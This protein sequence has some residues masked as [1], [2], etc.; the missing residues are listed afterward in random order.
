MTL[1]VLMACAGPAHR[2]LPDVPQADA[3]LPGGGAQFCAPA[4]AVDM[5]A[6]LADSGHPSLGP[7]DSAALRARVGELGEVMGVDPE[8]GTSLRRVS[9]GLATWL[10][11]RDVDAS[12][13]VIGWR[14]RD[15]A[16]SRGRQVTL[17]SV[18]SGLLPDAGALLNIGWYVEDEGTL[19]RVGGH[20]VALAGLQGRTAWVVDPSTRAGTT[21]VTHRVALTAPSATMLMGDYV[22]LPVWSADVLSIEGLVEPAG[23][24]QALVDGVVVVELTRGRP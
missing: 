6:W 10:E 5:L 21:P 14:P 15:D 8:R 20:W 24:E 4:A 9:R 18:R 13:R 2:E 22:G 1:A 23:V 16:H 7:T 11:G 19:T 12:V 3:A 17:E